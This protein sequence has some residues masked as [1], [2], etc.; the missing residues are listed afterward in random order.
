MITKQMYVISTWILQEGLTS[1]CVLFCDRCLD[2]GDGS[3]AGLVT[4]IHLL[5]GTCNKMKLSL[6]YSNLKTFLMIVS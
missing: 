6:D 3:V 1:Q 5:N 4:Q 2:K